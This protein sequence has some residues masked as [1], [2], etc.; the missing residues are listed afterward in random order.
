MSA[1]SGQSMELRQGRSLWLDPRDDAV[2]VASLLAPSRLFLATEGPRTGIKSV[3][4]DNH[5]RV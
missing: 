3:A 1:A 2:E 4:V 5:A